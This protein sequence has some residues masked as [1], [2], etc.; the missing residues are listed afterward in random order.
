LSIDL[1]QIVIIVYS[2]FIATFIFG[3][4]LVTFD[5]Y[6][7]HPMTLQKREEQFP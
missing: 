4:A 1:G 6:E 7:I 2:Q 5:P 3:M